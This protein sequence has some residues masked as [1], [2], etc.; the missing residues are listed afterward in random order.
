MLGL[1]DYGSDSE[2]END[3]LDIA[4]SQAVSS[5]T[6]QLPSFNDLLS[7]GS[8][9]PAGAGSPALNISPWTNH[10]NTTNKRKSDETLPS[11]S[12]SISLNQS[13]DDSKP[14]LQKTNPNLFL[15]PQLTRPNII[16]EDYKT[17]TTSKKSS[18]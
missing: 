2:N 7:S 10:Q 9:A 4:T 1:G 11:S 3:G 6:Y 8:T 13:D 15:P 12:A 14:K 5:S 18:T 16:T 17:W